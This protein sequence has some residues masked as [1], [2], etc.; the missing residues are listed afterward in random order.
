MGDGA[1][2]SGGKRPGRVV[3]R[4]NVASFGIAGICSSS[5]PSPSAGGG[6]SEAVGLL[7]AAVVADDDILHD[8]GGLD[9]PDRAS[10]SSSPPATQPRNQDRDRD[11][12]RERDKGR[13]RE[14]DRERDIDRDRDRGCQA[15]VVGHRAARE[16]PEVEDEEDEGQA[17]EAKLTVNMWA[18][19][20]GSAQLWLMPPSPS[21]PPKPGPKPTLPVP[22][23][24]S[25]NLAQQ[26]PAAAKGRKGMLMHLLLSP[27]GTPTTPQGEAG[28]AAAS[29][30]SRCHGDDGRGNFGTNP[31]KREQ[32]GVDGAGE[33]E[34]DGGGGEGGGDAFL[35]S[36]LGFGGRACL[37]AV[38]TCWKNAAVSAIISRSFARLL[39]HI[40]S[41]P[42]AANLAYILC[43]HSRQLI[44]ASALHCPAQTLH[45]DSDSDQIPPTQK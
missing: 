28:G 9:H 16:R 33:A 23:S 18:R 19:R 14:R 20:G 27:P 21:S 15:Q 7:A 34:T 6:D 13:D 45:R 3:K 4:R 5:S 24:P 17:M 25:D 31:S 29:A 10:S 1:G 26:K 39:L 30:T 12:D 40:L 42:I 11:R 37:M 41:I 43:I 2:R 38:F 35:D 32:G 36:L 22:P 8:V 44:L